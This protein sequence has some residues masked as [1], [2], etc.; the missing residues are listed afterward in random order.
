MENRLVKNLRAVALKH[1]LIIFYFFTHVGFILF[2][3]PLYSFAPDEVGYLITFKNLYNA[4]Q[5]GQPKI[6]G[7]WI[8]APTAFLW[9]SYLP[10]K[11]LTLVGV[12][13]YV[14]I[15]LLST[16][17]GT[18]SLYLIK[19]LLENCSY[20]KKFSQRAIFA[21]F[22]IP[23]I[24]FWTSLGIRESFIF[25]EFTAFLCGMVYLNHGK[26]RKAFFL[27]IAG[28]YGL[29]STKDYLWL[30]LML[31][32]FIG[33]FIFLVREGSRSTV[34]KLIIA[35]FLL[36]LAMFFSTTSIY[37]LNSIFNAN[38][39]SIGERSSQT[40]ITLSDTL[41]EDSVLG[42]IDDNTDDEVINI[43]GSATLNSLYN[44]LIE[45]PNAV[46]TRAIG[47]LKIDD[48]VRALWNETISIG[49]NSDSNQINSQIRI[50]ANQTLSPA[51][52]TQPFSF[53]PAGF[54]FLFG[55]IPFLG[56]LG[57]FQ[58][59][60]SLESPLWWILY[61]FVTLQFIRFRGSKIL[62]DLPIL[63][64][65]SFIL[66]GIAMSA[67]I[68]V[69]LGTSFRHRSILFIPL[70]FLYVRLAQLASTNRANHN[71]VQD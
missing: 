59:V 31:S 30:C 27:L 44:Y 50:N 18:L 51:K 19:K 21:F 25:I 15:R 17:L 10:A 55:P 32:V 5:D 65:F 48:R 11:L 63:V 7:G 64:T 56:E 22:F 46:F 53:I 33:S 38:I 20:Q 26:N 23:S 67:L 28:S 6:I 35:G 12:P 62:S 66:G 13:D 57:F 43:S 49:T 70:I 29:L 34:F 69:N 42:E 41:S 16:A 60:A 40:T 52:I 39:T 3:G 8:A 9:V 58:R 37:A 68:E 61:G 71:E 45:N 24:F 47:I 54:S 4:S 14:A 36:P 2:L 1:S